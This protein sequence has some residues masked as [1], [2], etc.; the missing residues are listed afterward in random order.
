MRLWQS[1]FLL[2]KEM[3]VLV[4]LDNVVGARVGGG[5]IGK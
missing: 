2:R 1:S 4:D 3:K 5:G